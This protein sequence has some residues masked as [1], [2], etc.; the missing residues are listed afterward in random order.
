M[1]PFLKKITLLN[2]AIIGEDV[3]ECY[4]LNRPYR[5]VRMMATQMAMQY[6]IGTGKKT[7]NSQ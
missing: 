4:R 2:I 5:C 7:G 3:D 6:T 1:S